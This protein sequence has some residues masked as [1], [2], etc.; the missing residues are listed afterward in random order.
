MARM[1]NVKDAV[2][3]DLNVSRDYLRV[4]LHRARGRLRIAVK[5]RGQA[6]V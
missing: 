4:L 6:G 2:C 5:G 3:K 1:K